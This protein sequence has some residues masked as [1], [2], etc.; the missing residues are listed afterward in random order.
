MGRHGGEYDGGEGDVPDEPV[1]QQPL[2]SLAAPDLQD[3]ERLFGH[4]VKKLQ[5]MAKMAK[6]L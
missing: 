1:V 3:V 2:V 4:G 5:L 6:K